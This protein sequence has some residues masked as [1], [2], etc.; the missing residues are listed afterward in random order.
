MTREE[1][2]GAHRGEAQYAEEKTVDLAAK[3]SMLG[4]LMGEVALWRRKRGAEI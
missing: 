4:V 1:R 2:E 3:A